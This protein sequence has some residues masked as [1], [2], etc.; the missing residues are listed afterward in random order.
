MTQFAV[1]YC[2]HCEQHYKWDDEVVVDTWNSILH[3]T[4]YHALTRFEIKEKGTYEEIV[5]KY[6][7][8]KEF[9]W[10]IHMNF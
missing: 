3:A 10:Q 4:C 9:R 7:Y 5:N 6:D 1:L 8:F 2:R